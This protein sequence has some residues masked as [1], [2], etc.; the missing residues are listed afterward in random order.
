M[1]DR[2]SVGIKP[3]I[4]P[5]IVQGIGSWWQRFP[6]NATDLGALIGFTPSN[7][8]T[9]NE[10]TGNFQDS[11]GAD[12]FTVISGTQNQASPFCGQQ[13]FACADGSLDS[14]DA[15][16][17]ASFDYDA[18]T[19][20][21]WLAAIRINVAAATRDIYA[22]RSAG[23]AYYRCYVTAAGQLYWAITDGVFSTVPN[24]AGGTIPIDY[25]PILTVVDRNAVQ[26]S[27][28][29]PGTTAIG[30]TLLI[31]SLANPGPFSFGSRTGFSAGVDFVWAAHFVGANAQMRTYEQTIL[32]NF[33]RGI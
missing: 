1:G 10:A 13:Q 17:A 33:W 12:A 5:G 26:S 14:A 4:R 7:I 19:S 21:A 32:S 6:T 27:I 3:H 8:W 11:V 2:I 16:N 9:F 31:G 23:A 29:I 18:V 22:R 20:F 30:S 28:S 15:V 24:I 25:F